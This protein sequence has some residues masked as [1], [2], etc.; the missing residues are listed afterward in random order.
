MGNA[1]HEGI[2]RVEVGSELGV[3][4]C[5]A[6]TVLKVVVTLRRSRRAGGCLDAIGSVFP[7]LIPVSCVNAFTHPTGCTDE[8]CSVAC[9]TSTGDLHERVRAPFAHE[10][11]EYLAP[12]ASNLGPNSGLAA[13]VNRHHWSRGRI[14]RL[15]PLES[16]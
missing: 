5:R 6:A 8:T 11:T 4:V 7:V 16:A 14:L 2:G 12:T 9:S 15:C 10:V 3:V 1:S 13:D